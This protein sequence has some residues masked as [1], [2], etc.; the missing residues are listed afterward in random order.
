M[1]AR[2]VAGIGGWFDHYGVHADDDG[3]VRWSHAENVRLVDEA[4]V[5]PSEEAW[6]RFWATLDDA[7]VWDWAARYEPDSPVMDGTSWMLEAEHDGRR[8][9]SSGSNAYPPRFADVC[10]AVAALSGGRTFR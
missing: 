2:L 6:E 10:Q 7:G 5:T 1:T 4:T 3:H 8:V 9:R